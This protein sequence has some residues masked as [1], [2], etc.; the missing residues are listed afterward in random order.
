MEEQPKL[1]RLFP[2]GTV[3]FPGAPLNLHVF[4]PRY[5]DMMSECLSE[6]EAFGVVLIREG[7]E[8]G[9]A[10]VLPHDVG[11]I[12]NIVDITPLDQGR[13]FVAT[14]GAQRFRLNRIVSREPHLVGEITLIK[15]DTFDE[16]QLVELEYE[17]REKYRDYRRLLVAFSVYNGETELP[18]DSAAASFI[19]ADALQIADVVK[20]RLLEQTDTRERFVTELGIL[21]R[22]VPQ[23]ESMIERR[24]EIQ[25]RREQQSPMDAAFR[26][27]QE[28]Y[29]GKYFSVN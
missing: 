18:T 10:D 3:L 20:Q 4:E 15:D 25:I 7:D 23:L 6:G 29:F 11:T 21:R 12:A 14:V 19:V 8:A 24:R 13:L 28:K 26:S 16:V 17:V 2:L 27:D 1:L 9:D 5:M 22:L